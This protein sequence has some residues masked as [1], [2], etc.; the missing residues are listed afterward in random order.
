M[1]TKLGKVVTY[2]EW[3]QF[4]KRYDPRSSREK[5][6]KLYV[7]F[8]KIYSFGWVLQNA[9]GQVLIDFFFPLRLDDLNGADIAYE[10]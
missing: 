2:R 7:H 1:S 5:L 3:R 9:K 10:K 8:H 4:L 6:I